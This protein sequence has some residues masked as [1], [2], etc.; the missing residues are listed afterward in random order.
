MSNPLSLSPLFSSLSLSA[1]PLPSITITIS[2]ITSTYILTF[3]V[4]STRPFPSLKPLP[5][6]LPDRISL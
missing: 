1:L 3:A 2:I 6:Q 5:R 4:P